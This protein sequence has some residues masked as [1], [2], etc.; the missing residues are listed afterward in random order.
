MDPNQLQG[1]AQPQMPAQMPAGGDKMPQ[2]ASPEDRQRLLDMIAQMKE[3][4]GEFNATSFAS[5]NQSEQHR[6]DMLKEVFAQ[7]A[8]AGVDLTD[9]ESVTKFLDTLRLQNPDLAQLF[10]EA[11]DALLGPEEPAEEASMVGTPPMMPQGMPPGGA[12]LG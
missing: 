4:L 6:M 1:M 2:M 3:K 9:P 12:E 5:Q 7:L 10:E 11:M 8:A